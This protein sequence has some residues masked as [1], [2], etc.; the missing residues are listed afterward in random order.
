MFDNDKG[1]IVTHN[2]FDSARMARASVPPWMAACCIG[3][4][5]T[6]SA[7]FSTTLSAA[8]SAAVLARIAHVE[9]GLLGRVT[10]KG[11]EKQTMTLP[12]RM[13][14]W[15]VPGVSI[16]VI[17]DGAIEW[18]RAYGVVD[19]AG[20]QAAT[21]AT[22]FQAASI[23]KL[24]TAVAALGLVE[25]GSLTLDGNVNPQLVSWKIPDNP[26][27]A[28]TPV[29]LRTLLSHTAGISL[30]PDVYAPAEKLPT[31]RQVLDGS[32]PSKTKAVRIE[33]V[34]G[35]AYRYSGAGYGVVQQLMEDVSK[36]PFPHIMKTRLFE[37]LQ[38]DNSS[39]DQ[40]LPAKFAAMAATG[41]DL[42]GVPL[43]GGWHTHPVMAAGGLWSTPTDLAKLAL[44]LQRAASGKSNKIISS[45]MVAS[46]FT[47][48]LEEYGLGA[49]LSHDGAA[50]AF[51]HSGSNLGYKALLF[52]YTATGKGAVI[53]TNGDYGSSLIDEIMRSIATEYGW[54]DYLPLEKTVVPGKPQ[55][56][57]NFVGVYGVAGTSIKISSENGQLFIEGPPLGPLKLALFPETEHSY[58]VREQLITV[59]FKDNGGKAVDEIAFGDERLGAKPRP[60]VRVK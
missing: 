47:P 7:T 37:P 42:Q 19:A 38:M 24:A 59:T 9:N 28:T 10:I 12:E 56:H 23:S 44:E 55:L 41:H 14:V 22:L 25:K 40:V 20:T 36:S 29:S 48:V 1:L 2:L 21:T 49:E 11:A 34:P 32:A 52:A 3:L 39:F 45:G 31:L 5:G 51:S 33:T 8:E 35:T 53:L 18:A 30:D 54:S 4:L 43:K 16:A 27:T 50:T 17:N 58:F 60:G 57:A 15:H 13:K 6:F 26:F 46:M